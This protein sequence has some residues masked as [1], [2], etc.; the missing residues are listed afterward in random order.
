[1]KLNE[2]YTSGGSFLKAE[3]LMGKTIKVTISEVSVHTFD[4]GTPKE[5]KQ[6][7]LSF[8]G[9]ELKLGLN[10]T[11]A[12]SIAKILGDDTDMWVGG[13]IKIYPTTTDFGDKKDVPCIRV[14]EELP[15]EADGEGIPF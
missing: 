3:H 6:L 9:K 13:Q 7:V 1:M 14:I 12:N 10:V 15:P 4:E 2:V 11:N 8:D 5:K